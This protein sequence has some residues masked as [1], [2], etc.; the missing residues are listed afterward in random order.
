MIYI[1][2]TIALVANAM[3]NI[4][5]KLGAQ[6]FSGGLSELAVRPWMFVVNIYLLS[7]LIFFGVA[8]VFYTVVL[9][10]LNLSVAYPIMT[11]LGFLIVIG[12]SVW[13]LDESLFWWQ[14]LGIAMIMAGVV[15][16]SQGAV[17]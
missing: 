4:F 1:F 7:G 2:L 5:I 6:Q 8:L 16:L 9:S 14:W 11:S 17:G 13:G 15:L 12:F 3:A 10:K